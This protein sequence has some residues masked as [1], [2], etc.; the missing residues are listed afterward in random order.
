MAGRVRF[1]RGA[2]GTSLPETRQ[3]G[4]I[5]ILEREGS[6]GFGDMYVDM[7]N[8]HRLHI[9]PDNSL[10]PYYKQNNADG[11]EPL[12][13]VRGTVYFYSGDANESS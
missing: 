9:A 7:D 12:A 8:G 13:S 5:F 6:T 4:A 3:N 1:Y 2:A 11:D 10:V